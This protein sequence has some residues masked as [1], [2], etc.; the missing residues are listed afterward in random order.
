MI[1]IV[2]GGRDYTNK[3]RVYKALDAAHD[4]RPITLLIQG[5]ARGADKLARQW[6]I[7]RG[8]PF[9]DEPA[10]WNRYDKAAGGIRNSKMLTLDPE[11][12]IAF[13]GGDGTADM[14]KKS[15]RAGLT[16]WQPYRN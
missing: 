9:H 8:V 14:V 13:P 7:D 10:D 15:R 6:A 4:A 11:A 3:A 12:C 1:V 16:V 5:Y 2:C